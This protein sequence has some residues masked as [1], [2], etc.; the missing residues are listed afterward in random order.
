MELHSVGSVEGFQGVHVGGQKQV[1][2]FARKH[3]LFPKQKHFIVLYL[4]YD[5]LEKP[6]K[7]LTK[8]QQQQQQ[9]QKTN[10]QT[11]KKQNKTKQ[12]VVSKMRSA[13]YRVWM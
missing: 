10:K 6:Q 8:Q 13:I 2:L 9:Q 5:R 3:N 4:K 7:Q 1:K 12:K 11:N